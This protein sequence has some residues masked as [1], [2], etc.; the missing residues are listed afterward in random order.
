MAGWTIRTR[1]YGLYILLGALA[2]RVLWAIAVPVMPL[3]DSIAYDT[4][5]INLARC[6]NYG[7]TC[8]E[9]TAYWPVGTSFVYAVLYSIFGHRFWPIIVLN[10]GLALL[11]IG[12][13]MRLA[14]SWFNVRVGI[15]AG[16]LLALWPSQIQFTTVLASEPLFTALILLA[17]VLWNRKSLN[18]RLQSV[19]VGAVLA[20]AAYV[21]PT[22]LLMPILFLSWQHLDK[23]WLAIRQRLIAVLLMLIVIALLIAPWSMRNTYAF[24]KFTGLS[25]N[26]GANLWMG[27]NP[28]SVGEYMPLPPIVSSMNEAER[29]QFLKQQATAHIRENPWLFAK[30]TAIRVL[31]VHSRESIGIAW[32]E[33]G[34]IS[35]YGRSILLPLKVVNQIYWLLMLGLGLGGLGLLIYRQGWLILLTHPAPALWLYFTAIHAVIVAQDRYHFPSVPMIAVLAAWALY[36]LGQRIRFS[37]MAIP[38]TSTAR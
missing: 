36:S 37:A 22:A 21:R 3:S 15:L 2:L 30:R 4:F 9:P 13:T 26:G 1:R 19:K 34:L 23:N 10:I 35:R 28:N 17:L 6:R 32:N 11:T 14:S 27:N 16:L 38:D 25:T 31:Q 29:D 33:R 20:A 5:A 24:G 7:W 18:T 8:Q 12:L